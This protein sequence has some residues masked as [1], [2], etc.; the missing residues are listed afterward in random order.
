MFRNDFMVC[1]EDEKKKNRNRRAALGV[2]TKTERQVCVCGGPSG[3]PPLPPLPPPPAVCLKLRAFILSAPSCRSVSLRGGVAQLV[4]A[5]LQVGSGR[6]LV[7][8]L[9]GAAAHDD[10]S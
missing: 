6:V 10:R 4:E 3:D 7:P 5:K 2:L 9:C 1:A 8:Q